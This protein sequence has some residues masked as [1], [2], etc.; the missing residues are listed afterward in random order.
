MVCATKTSALF[1]RGIHFMSSVPNDPDVLEVYQAGKLT[2]VGF[3]REEVLDYINVPSCR[4]EIMQLI[5]AHGCETLAF[6]F[7]GVK[8]IPSGLLGLLAS[9]R[10]HNVEIYIYNPSS[11]IREVLEI[12]KLDQM[13]QIHEV[14]L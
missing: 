12:T 14:E 5:D 7:T 2:V 4:D 1:D 9:M 10:V 13:L 3:N 6:D 8:L 11:D